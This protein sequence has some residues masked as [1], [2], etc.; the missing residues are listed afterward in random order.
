MTKWDLAWIYKVGTTLL[1]QLIY[2]INKINEKTW[3]VVGGE[4]SF[5]RIQHSFHFSALK[6]EILF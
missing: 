2:Y 4:K 3:Y 5:H 1:N 6:T